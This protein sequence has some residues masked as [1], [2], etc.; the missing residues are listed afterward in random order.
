V[1]VV[2]EIGK[3]I[4]GDGAD[5][6][7]TGRYPTPYATGG[8]E[9]GRMVFLDLTEETGGNANGVGM[10]DVVT[11]R[12]ASKI[13]RPATYLNALT[14]TTP[15]PVKLPMVMPT[16]RLAITAALEM[17]A[18]VSPREVRLV[19]VKNTLKL[20]QMHVS[21][22]VLTEV[23]KDERLRV[24]QEPEPMRFGDEGSLV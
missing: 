14:S 12:L 8:P 13:D 3:N 5:P 21:E 7:V 11:E 6:N 19:R 10:A 9:V 2:D 4:S 20:R 23:E 22:A 1:L 17:C 15:Q 18:G 24:V 16:D